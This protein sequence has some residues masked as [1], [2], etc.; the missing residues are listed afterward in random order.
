MW[1]WPNKVVLERVIQTDG[2]SVFNKGDTRFRGFPIL[3]PI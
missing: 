3:S 2:R 1:P